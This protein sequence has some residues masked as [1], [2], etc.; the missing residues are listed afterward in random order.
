MRPRDASAPSWYKKVVESGGILRTLDEAA[1][2]WV[3]SGGGPLPVSGRSMRPTFQDAARVWM[4]ESPR[5]RFGDVLVYSS[6]SFL[7]VH[8]V[9]GR[10]SGPRYRTKGDGLASL[11]AMVVPAGRVIG[12]VVE[13][14]R[15]GARYRVDRPGGRIYGSLL[16]AVSA[17]EGFLF[18]FAWRLDRSVMRLVAP[19][20]GPGGP[21]IVRRA[22]DTTGRA[23]I[24]LIDRLL[25]KALHRPTATAP[26]R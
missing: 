15:D 14:E 18:R 24:G 8:R 16:A 23:A 9:V 4:R 2:L 19:G 26:T 25:F 11:D 17:V 6:G 21:M 5:V 10:K 3:E 13:I 22:L 1:R 7:V 20:R 12:V